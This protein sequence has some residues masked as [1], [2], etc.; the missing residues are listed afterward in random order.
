MLDII[1]DNNSDQIVDQI[2]SDFNDPG[3]TL[4][5]RIEIKVLEQEMQSSY[6]KYAMSVIA[7]RALPDVRD[8]LKPV[9]RR[10]IYSM[11][12]LGLTPGAKYRKSATV[13]GDVLGKY[14]PHGDLAVYNSMVRMAQ[15]FALRYPLIDGQGNFGSIDGDG[16]A[17]MRYTEVRMNKPAHFL[18]QDLDK[19][20]VDFIDNYDGSTKEPTVLP[21]LLPN[22]LL[23]GTTGIA[24]GMATNIPPHNASELIGAIKL[25][26][27]NPEASIDDLLEI[28]KGPDLPTGGT[29]LYQDTLREA[30]K[31]GIGK[32]SIKAKARIEDNTIIISEI[33]Y[34]VN[35]AECL[36]R[37]AGLIKD[38]KIEG[39][40]DI[41]DE[42]N[43]D[44]IRIVIELKRDT[45]PEVVLNNLYKQTELQKNINFNMLALVN[46][47]R[48]PK[49]LN[50]KEILV[51]FISHRVEVITRRTQ[52][53][54]DGALAELHI[55]EGLK[56]ALDFID[57]VV[58]MIRAS[59]N[60]QEASSKL[61]LR[62]KLSV[63]QA[64]AI[65]QM[66]LQTLTGMDKQKIVDQVEALI[67][68]IAELKNILDNP[69]VLQALMVAELDMLEDKLP[70][71]R[72]TK[73]DYDT[74]VNYSNEDLIPNDQVYIQLTSKQYFKILGVDDFKSQGRGGKGVIGFNAKNEDYVTY[75]NVCNMHDYISVFTNQGRIYQSRIYQMPQGSRV[76]KGENLI[77]YFKLNEGEKI[78]TILTM[79]KE[80]MLLENAY[81]IFGLNDGSIKKTKL[82]EYKTVNQ[83][84]KYAL[85]LDEGQ[86]VIAVALSNS[87][88]DDVVMVGSNG[89]CGIFKSLKVNSKGRIAGGIKG[90]VLPKTD[91]EL[92]NMQVSR[93]GFTEDEQEPQEL[94]LEETVQT[95][96]KFPALLVI[97]ENGFGKLS[98]LGLYRQT[99]RG[100]KGVI[101]YKESKKTG[102]VVFSQIVYGTEEDVLITTKNGISIKID[103]QDINSL[104]RNSIGTKLIKVDN[105]DGV[106]TASVF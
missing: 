43:K 40:R 90:L 51:E 30:Y 88:S 50:L 70:K 45:I 46:R 31:T 84:G 85:K 80:D 71:G 41:R 101:T 52:F 76:G 29:A 44:G 14:H 35:K 68:L 61:Q 47:G 91:T 21:N 59:K 98:H 36:I 23:N 33:P 6:L 58:A 79:T 11:Y 106:A 95:T 69:E 64:E 49:L 4:E 2:S 17:A 92:V 38:K 8:G 18:V 82:D 48:Q 99:N 104:G 55:L 97:S 78:K 16:A 65:L 102:K 73:I 54:L 24:V 83:S 39:I 72:L 34:E 93:F 10:I 20:T 13:V 81:L 67:L 96:T 56:I 25:I 87:D 22:L 74:A 12:R 103:L 63:K 3:T 100:T 89:R 66:R 57:E 94:F 28:I 86:S 62:F 60:K 9:H 15:D 27:S 75:S 77:N 5:D 53:D 37:I 26:I 32:V 42:S 105:N 7:S 1:K 19:N